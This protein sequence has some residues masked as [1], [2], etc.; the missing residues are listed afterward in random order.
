MKVLVNT[1]T[2]T[3]ERNIDKTDSYVK[4]EQENPEQ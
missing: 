3:K 2:I 4:G 1:M